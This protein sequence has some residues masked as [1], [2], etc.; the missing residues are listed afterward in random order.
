[1][2]MVMNAVVNVV[3]VLAVDVITVDVDIAVIIVKKFSFEKK[4][5]NIIVISGGYHVLVTLGRGTTGFLLGL[6]SA[7]ALVAIRFPA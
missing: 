7:P 6:P 4:T 5:C 2:M 3:V 1:M